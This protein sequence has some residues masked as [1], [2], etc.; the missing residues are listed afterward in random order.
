LKTGLTILDLNGQPITT[1]LDI[2]DI[3]ATF[4]RDPAHPKRTAFVASKNPAL[5]EQVV[6]LLNRK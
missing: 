3:F 1:C 5:A 2:D 4:R 6:R